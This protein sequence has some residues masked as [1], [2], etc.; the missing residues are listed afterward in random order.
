MADNKTKIII[1]TE[2]GNTEQKLKNIAGNLQN[3]STQTQKTGKV[4]AS[5]TSSMIS[6]YVAL[7][8]KV[9]AVMGTIK[10]AYSMAR[11]AASFQEIALY[12]KSATENIGL[13]F[14]RLKEASERGANGMA[15]SVTIM[16]ANLKALKQ[17]LDA[18]EDE[19]GK[20]WEI[21]NATGDELGQ[22]IE[23]TFDQITQAINS[24][25][26]KA[27]MQ[28]GV[29]PESF[30][31]S[32]NA[33]E[34]LT[35]KSALL[36]TVLD[37]LGKSTDRLNQYGDTAFDKFQQFE[38]ACKDLSLTVKE[39][40]VPA[41]TPVITIL[42]DIIKA[43][44]KASNAL[45]LVFGMKE[46][47]NPYLAYKKDDLLGIQSQK[48]N[49]ISQYR[50]YADIVSGKSNTPLQS[51]SQSQRAEIFG[52]NKYN[53]ASMA[54]AEEAR[55][56][57]VEEALEYI[58]KLEEKRLDFKKKQ[59]DKIKSD[60]ANEA[61]QKEKERMDREAEK[62]AEAAKRAAEKAREEYRKFCDEINSG[63]NKALGI[64][65]RSLSDFVALSYSAGMASI[66]LVSQVDTLAAELY[67]LEKPFN[68][69]LEEEEKLRDVEIALENIDSI[70][71]EN[72]TKASNNINDVVKA[73]NE[74][75]VG[76]A[77]GMA[78]TATKVL[79]ITKGTVK[80]EDDI[81]RGW[82]AIK[83]QVVES[84]SEAVT[85][86]IINSNI[87]DALR[88]A[89]TS[90]AGAKAQS[91][92]SNILG[93]LFSGD[94]IATG[95]LSGFV[96]SLAVGYVANNWK[97][98]FSDRGKQES[99]A[100]NQSTVQSAVNAYFSTYSAMFNPYM[101]DDLYEDLLDARWAYRTGNLTVSNK[102]KPRGGLPGL[103]GYKDYRDTTPS[104]TYSVID[105]I[106]NT[107]KTVEEYNK[108]KEKELDLLSAQGKDYQ[109]LSTQV[110][111][112]KQTMDRVQ[113]YGLITD[114]WTFWG[115][116]VGTQTHYE[117]D[118]SD[119]IQDLKKAYYEALREYGGETGARNQ[120]K[121]S[122]FL[123]LFPFLDNYTRGFTAKGYGGYEAFTR[124][125]SPSATY[126]LIKG[127]Q[128]NL[129]DSY[130]DPRMLE[131]IKQAGKEQ[132]ELSE[133]Q[134]TD[135]G[136]KY[137]EAYLN[138]LERQRDAAAL[139][140]QEQE[141]IYSD[142]TRTF[143]EQQAA[144]DTYQQAQGQYYNTKLEILAQERAK[145]EQLKKEEQQAKL[146]SA[147]RMEALLGFTGEM[148]RT[149]NKIYILE[150]AD[151]IGAL[152][153]LEQYIDDPEALSF[154]KRLMTAATNKNKYGKIA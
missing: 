4:V 88:G 72:L 135:G 56:K 67:E 126:N 40:L 43:A 45:S 16:K 146:R 137:A 118:L 33:A 18:T 79:D 87:G 31:K 109:V 106:N 124:N 122:T 101:T 37:Q 54:E 139:V 38:N 102:G 30:K 59:E 14:E 64:T 27:L 19:I 47:K 108:Y 91:Y 17:G 153:E 34:L 9:A 52:V 78:S 13:S 12:T 113:S 60:A 73:A 48:R 21:A 25:N 44:T 141:Q 3:I 20:L 35:N 63:L 26:G 115:N 97:K 51:L 6:N 1:E 143:Q 82:A 11:E 86:G 128:E 8:A 57:Q 100:K 151:Q 112:L 104:S 116:M 103:A 99:I 69:M 147:D 49:E 144:L 36:K 120:Q 150:G 7:G 22:S 71:F 138:V 125:D 5:S 110:N 39:N 32:A 111:A 75:W 121:A 10:K 29:I 89:I 83:G 68:D 41:L 136:S 131:L 96:G 92:G 117:L 130:A 23:Q 107:V 154:V 81:K 90:L 85:S 93:S 74:L 58:N 76:S 55:L 94:K 28:L 148:A 77:M 15:D 2:S 42:T 95:A 145:E 134:Y 62:A 61:A 152:R 65:N 80:P 123:N 105:A 24:G 133:L 119:N 140:M 70:K 129:L 127:V 84:F 66:G 132:F 142:M 53:W 98:W 46:T 50:Y 114:D 149:N